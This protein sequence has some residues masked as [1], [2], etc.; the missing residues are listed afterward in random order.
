MMAPV[1]TD[2]DNDALLVAYLDGE[3]EP[4]AHQKLERR[5]RTEA[6]L[7]ARLAALAEGSAPL[8]SSF[9]AMLEAAPRARLDA[10]FAAALA[11]APRRR[12]YRFREMLLAAAAALLLLIGGGVAGYFIAKPPGGIFEEADEFEEEWIA[13]V[14]GQLSLYEGA[15]VASIPVNDAEQ[16]ARLSKLGEVLKLDLSQPRVAFEGLTLKRV[17]LLNFQGRKVGELLYASE[18]GPVALCIMAE[19]GGEGEGEV[20]GRDGLNFMY[21]AASGRRFLLIGAVPEKTIDAL[22]NT[23]VS[24]FGT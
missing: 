15:A 18:Q 24:R 12:E 8:R 3:L 17:E 22:A 9:D 16:Q 11:R 1:P 21:W 19:P 23:I 2:I 20:E 10:A 13:A 5:L 7:S 6:A 4:E 14:A